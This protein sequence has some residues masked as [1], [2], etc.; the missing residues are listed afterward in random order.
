MTR[1]LYDDLESLTDCEF[2]EWIDYLNS[3]QD[4][5]GLYRDPLIFDKGWFVNDPL[6]CGRPHLSCHVIT[7]LT[8]LGGIASKPLS[9]LREFASIDFLR[10]WLESRDWGERVAYTGNEIM[11]IGTLMQYARD[12]HNEQWAGNTITF[13]LDWLESNHL[14]LQFGVWG[15]IDMTDPIWRSHAVQAAYH[16]WPLFTYDRRPIPCADRAI[17][18]LLSTQNPRGG[19]GWGVHNETDPWNSS[20]CEDIDS[21]EPLARLSMQTDYRRSD[22]ESAL[23]KAADWVLF[24]LTPDGGF[25]FIRDVPFE[26]GHP[27]LRGEAG[28]GAM[29]P[30]WFRTLSLA[31]IGMAL[32][33]HPLGEYEWKFINCPGFQF[34]RGGTL[35][36]G[37]LLC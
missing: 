11:N 16:W 23:I 20:A 12:F 2:V 37:T 29:F 4:D 10:G 26:Y 9:L 36:A 32:P 24:N 18:T 21:I 31:C 30:T 27:E 14:D 34:A 3:H 35:D 15:D 6:W 13:I 17:D 19:F 8:A 7:A 33:E 1:S 25:V 22:I 28:R 5:D